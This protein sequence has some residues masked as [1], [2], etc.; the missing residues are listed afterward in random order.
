[1]ILQPDEETLARYRVEAEENRTQAAQ[2]WKGSAIIPAETSD[3][4]RIQLMGNIEFPYEVDHCVE[5]GADG[6]GLY[7]TEFLYLG[8]EISP[9]EEVHYQAYCRVVQAMGDRPVVIRTFDLGADKMPDMPHPEDERNPCLGLRSIRL[10][11]RSLPIFRTQLRA[12]LRATVLGNVQIMFPLVST[13]LELR[14]AKMVLADVMEDL[15]EHNVPFNRDVPVGMMVET[16]A[17]VM[18]IGPLRRGGRFP[19]HRHQRPDPVHAGR[20]PEQ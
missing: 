11:L 17:A 5:R 20:G 12:V 6:V 19:Q 15:Q 18:M 14:Q 3:G 10:A 8:A 2:A 9:T 13:M 4:V 16:P 1:M 7:R